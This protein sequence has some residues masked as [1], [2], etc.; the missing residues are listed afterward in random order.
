MKTELANLIEPTVVNLGYEL[1]DL[2]LKLG[3]RDGLVRVF[4]DKPEGVDL[5]DCEIV[6]KQLSA[7]LDVEDPIGG[8][9]TLEVWHEELGK[10]KTEKVTVEAGKQAKLDH[11]MGAKKKS[12]K[13]RRR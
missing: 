12:S 2:E 11:T 6:S 3:G 13:K 4:I 10:G 8:E 5:T 9:Y 1:S 7:V